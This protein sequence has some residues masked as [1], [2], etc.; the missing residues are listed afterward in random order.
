MIMRLLIWNMAMVLEVQSSAEK[1]NVFSL[2]AQDQPK[3]INSLKC[4]IK[5]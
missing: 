2:L 5:A 1:I 3:Y 4:L